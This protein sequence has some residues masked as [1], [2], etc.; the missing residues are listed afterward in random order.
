MPTP[1]MLG[2]GPPARAPPPKCRASRAMGG[3]HHRHD[4]SPDSNRPVR[5]N[6][7]RGR[8]S[9]PTIDALTLS[10]RLSKVLY[11]LTTLHDP[12]RVNGF[13]TAGTRRPTSTFFSRGR[14]AT[15]EVGMVLASLIVERLVRTG[16]IRLIVDDTLGRHTGKRVAGASMQPG[17]TT[18]GGTAAVLPLG[19]R[20]G[21]ARNRG[22][23]LREELGLAHSVSGSSLP[24]IRRD[25]SS[26]W[27]T[28]PTPTPR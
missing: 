28:P 11:S 13:E 14:W 15:D 27:V 9:D 1:R 7:L 23:A 3:A 4:V 22:N 6:Q 17:S 21:R 19:A 8:D 12:E 25:A 2:G 5:K 26:S 10:W 20:V 18:H 16:V 24:A